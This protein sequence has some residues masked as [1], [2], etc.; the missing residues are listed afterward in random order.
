MTI[1]KY[2]GTPQDYLTMSQFCIEIVTI[3]KY[4]KLLLCHMKKIVTLATTQFLNTTGDEL[5]RDQWN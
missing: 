5:I 4:L 2:C 1:V 3:V